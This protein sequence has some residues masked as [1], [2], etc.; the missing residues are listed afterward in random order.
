MS[1]ALDSQRSPAPAGRTHCDVSEIG[2]R[3]STPSAVEPFYAADSPEE[4]VEL[5]KTACEDAAVKPISSFVKLLRRTALPEVS[6]SDSYFG[7]RGLGPVLRCLRSAKVASLSLS[8]CMLSS[9]HI[10][11]VRRQLS[12]H[13]FLTHLDVTCNSLGPQSA[14]GLLELLRRSPQLTRVDVDA[15]TSKYEWIQQVCLA[16]RGIH[17]PLTTCA[18]C[19]RNILGN[20]FEE[21]EATL[22]RELSR[23]AQTAEAQNA[24][25]ECVAAVWAALRAALQKN[26]NALSVCGP[27]CL[28]EWV[29]QLVGLP[30]LVPTPLEEEEES[31][32]CHCGVSEDRFVGA[33]LAAPLS[34]M[35]GILAA[36][37]QKLPARVSPSM[38]ARLVDVLNDVSV[39]RRCA[40]CS[41]RCGRAVV[42]YGLCGGG[43]LL[44]LE[45]D[46]RDWMLHDHF[47][48]LAVPFA[49]FA[50]S[51]DPVILGQTELPLTAALA[52]GQ[53]CQ[54]RGSEGHDPMYTYAA[55]RHLS[56]KDPTRGWGCDLRSACKAVVRHGLLPAALAPFQPHDGVAR[57]GAWSSWEGMDELHKA[58]S[59]RKKGAFFAIDPPP[60]GMDLFDA[61]LSASYGLLPAR[62]PIVTG[63]KWR[64]E[65]TLQREGVVPQRPCK[66]GL[67]CAVRVL[68]QRIINEVAHLVVAPNLGRGVGDNGLFYFCREVANREMRYGSF[69][70]RDLA[71]SGIPLLSAGSTQT[72]LDKRG[73]V[74]AVLKLLALPSARSGDA[75]FAHMMPAVADVP[76]EGRFLFRSKRVV[77]TQHEEDQLTALRRLYKSGSRAQIH[78]FWECQ[79]PAAVRDW[80]VR[81]LHAREE[82]MRQAAAAPSRSR[83]VTV[84]LKRASTTSLGGA[85]SILD[86]EK[87]PLKKKVSLLHM[88]SGERQAHLDRERREEQQLAE[89]SN[90]WEADKRELQEEQ[91]ARA[92]KAE[93]LFTKALNATLRLQKLSHQFSARGA[94][95][96]VNAKLAVSQLKTGVRF[97][98]LQHVEG[99]DDARLSSSALCFYGDV[100]ATVHTTQPATPVKFQPT[101]SLERFPF[102]NGIDAVAYPAL[103]AEEVAYLFSKEAWV[104]YS[105]R[106]RRATSSPHLL[107]SHVT[108]R[109]LPQLFH[110]GIS[111]AVS[112]PGTRRSYLVQGR[113]VVLWDFDA[114][115]PVGAVFCLGDAATAFARLPAE[116][117]GGLQACAYTGDETCVLMWDGWSVGWSLANMAPT[118]KPV[119]ACSASS[120][121]HL[122][123]SHLSGDTANLMRRQSKHF[124]DESLDQQVPYG[125][126]PDASRAHQAYMTVAKDMASTRVHLD[127]CPCGVSYAG[128]RLMLPVDEAEGGILDVVA[129]LLSHDFSFVPHHPQA[130]ARVGV[131]Q[132]VPAAGAAAAAGGGDGAAD[133][134]RGVVAFAFPA[135]QSFGYVQ[136]AGVFAR[137][138]TVHVEA[139]VDSCAWRR[140]ATFHADSYVSPGQWAPHEASRCWRVVMENSTAG[141]ALHRVHW[142]KVS[143]VADTSRYGLLRTVSFPAKVSA[144]A[145]VIVNPDTLCPTSDIHSSTS[146][147]AWNAKNGASGWYRKHCVI[148]LLNVDG[149]PSDV[150][151]FLTGIDFVAWCY[152]G[153]C[154]LQPSASKLTRSDRFSNLPRPFRDVGIDAAVYACPQANPFLVYL[155]SDA[156]YV[157]WNIHDNVAESDVG[158]LGAAGGKFADLPAPFCYGLDTATHL[159]HADSADVAFFR[160]GRVLV[161]NLDTAQVVSGG[162]E[163]GAG[164]QRGG[165]VFGELPQAA[166]FSDVLCV[167]RLPPSAGEGFLVLSDGT[168]M[169]YAD[170]GVYLG[171]IALSTHRRYIKLA[172]VLAWHVME[173]NSWVMV[174]LQERPQ[175]FVGCRVHC[176]L[177]SSTEASFKVQYSDDSQQWDTAAPL[178][179]RGSAT[180][181]WVFTAVRRQSHR[182]WRLLL[183][184]YSSA[185]IAKIEWLNLPM[186]QVYTLPTEV[187]TTVDPCCEDKELDSLFGADP[188]PEYAHFDASYGEYNEGDS[189][190]YDFGVALVG[191]VRLQCDYYTET[192]SPRSLKSSP[193]SR[194]KRMF[195]VAADG[196]EGSQAPPPQTRSNALS[197]NNS[198]E[199]AMYAA[200]EKGQWQYLGT[201]ACLSDGFGEAAWDPFDVWRFWKLKL[202]KGQCRLLRIQASSYSGPLPLVGTG[203]SPKSIFPQ[204]LLLLDAETTTCITPCELPPGRNTVLHYDYKDDPQVFVKV[205]IHGTFGKALKGAWSVENSIDGHKWTPLSTC[206]PSGAVAE[207]TWPVCP[208]ARHWRVKPSCDARISAIQWLVP[209]ASVGSATP[210]PHSDAYEVT[211]TG[212]ETVAP[213]KKLSQPAAATGPPAAAGR[214]PTV[215]LASKQTV[216]FATPDGSA[217]ALRGLVLRTA[218]AAAAGAEVRV[219]AW[220]GDAA[221]DDAGSDEEAGVWRCVC[222]Q[223]VRAAVERLDWSHVGGASRWRVQLVEGESL[224]VVG[225]TWLSGGFMAYVRVVPES[226]ECSDA[227]Q[228]AACRRVVVRRCSGGGGEPIRL[229]KHA[230][231]T[232]C[233]DRPQ[234]LLRCC[235]EGA[236][237]FRVLV[238]S[239][240]GTGE[241][242]VVARGSKVL[243]WTPVEQQTVWRV[244]AWSGGCTVN[245]VTMLA[246]TPSRSVPSLEPQQR[247]SARVEAHLKDGRRA[248]EAEVAAE[249]VKRCN[250]EARDV[251][252]RVGKLL[253]AKKGQ[254]RVSGVEIPALAEASKLAALSDLDGV[255]GGGLHMKE[256]RLH[257]PFDAEDHSLPRLE[258]R[259][260]LKADWVGLSGSVVLS[261]IWRRAESLA[262]T[263]PPPPTPPAEHI[264]LPLVAFGMQTDWKPIATFPRCPA[265]LYLLPPSKTEALLVA[266]PQ[267]LQ[268]SEAT[269]LTGVGPAGIG[270][271][272]GTKQCTFR[273]KPG[274]S[275][276]SSIEKPAADNIAS[277]LL[278]L[279]S[280]LMP[281][282]PV[283]GVYHTHGLNDAAMTL[284]MIT[285]PL[286][287]DSLGATAGNV[288]VQLAGDA[289]DVT[290]MRVS[291]IVEW[292]GITFD[293]DGVVEQRDDGN[294]R[295]SGPALSGAWE[296][297]H[298]VPDGAFTDLVVDIRFSAPVD[299]PQ[300]LSVSAARVFGMLVFPSGMSM[301]FRIDVSNDCTMTAFTPFLSLAD[302]LTFSLLKPVNAA[303][304]EC[305]WLR[306]TVCLEDVTLLKGRVGSELGQHSVSG[307]LSVA[308]ATGICSVHAFGGGRAGAQVNA[309]VPSISLGL[310]TLQRVAGSR[311]VAV[312][313]TLS[314]EGDVATFKGSATL[315]GIH[316]VPATVR[317]DHAA[318]SFAIEGDI[319]GSAALNAHLRGTGVGAAPFLDDFTMS[320]TLDSTKVQAALCD[321]VLRLP[322]VQGIVGSGLQFTLRLD[323]LELQ[324]FLLSNPTLVVRFVGVIV[325]S[326]FDVCA[327]L[328]PECADDFLPHVA[329]EI[330]EQCWAPVLKFYQEHGERTKPH[331]LKIANQPAVS[332][333]DDA[334]NVAAVTQDDW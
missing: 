52:V 301:R 232:M 224:A 311:G 210:S 283:T 250:A 40:L 57:W 61:L 94:Q 252:K 126:P 308:G 259:A 146:L 136:V 58:A 63:V 128:L 277:P 260:E 95:P 110:A 269:K 153:E 109:D 85:E 158:I 323:G 321:L 294:L 160:Q 21:L 316:N 147:V 144:C 281:E 233:F 62:R 310:L 139:S 180:V 243:S 240:D 4:L 238:P 81:L 43:G 246:L 69:A 122:L 220:V 256:F 325:G 286:T 193:R 213:L 149:M 96:I 28:H 104:T 18:Y 290:S 71:A 135:A 45:G 124:L 166:A 171:P 108:F 178:T 285:G 143:T 273:L 292:K 121:L 19:R 265:L 331:D 225:C 241:W 165:D 247:S 230:H 159:H 116:L 32:C 218:G 194:S 242:E 183:W 228:Q 107:S 75:F 304:A 284:T 181:T 164:T 8:A 184:P 70:F 272:F 312:A 51:D 157:L 78:F 237:E 10:A 79:N 249:E 138:A 2:S 20:T 319:G 270:V 306:S 313:I 56:H 330:V 90:K 173:N 185:R 326:D 289:Q 98:F 77:A 134:A 305:R 315:V 65:W 293:V 131:L 6:L 15:G 118:G 84:R 37:L 267:A 119:H 161:W 88:S 117:R 92:V 212:E 199:W 278:H 234:V 299:S 174:D 263:A 268:I 327:T 226:V 223:P 175:M 53:T 197:C 254:S 114:K 196:A 324:P 255:L 187:T 329:S 132:I 214:Q 333:F 235:I 47:G 101:A 320:G 87:A 307:R 22:L 44:P 209:H 176:A 34:F 5:Y 103:H 274:V 41:R 276:V 148:P 93:L 208:P 303:H 195:P 262:S 229:A 169:H 64:G 216:T 236:G 219:E 170:G 253:K 279:L 266:T 200:R 291:T 72:I 245:S 102:Y 258:Y 162:V 24:S 141:D 191:S 23:S 145:P 7:D 123:P 74:E 83:P 67:L 177:D 113:S 80:L 100:V 217:D 73:D 298:D 179:V 86:V 198:C 189:L 231:F 264:P 328:N 13:P 38:F 36:E 318:T 261:L 68:G 244:E 207:L 30:P 17:V 222:T 39:K 190:S 206:T 275:V 106:D 154:P 125:K 89:A 155:F 188:V 76:C 27:E 54:N 150:A 26:G 82:S 3:V 31:A 227:A 211:T 202:V 130:K 50:C 29:S 309:S 288:C 14:K 271:S 186:R 248:P 111:C 9:E 322:L 302:V 280:L 239:G 317:L 192:M 46:S 1:L 12:G 142:Y 204:A 152:P 167:A 48:V 115:Q 205:V 25:N 129:S 251:T 182:F 297:M 55:A 296:D 287:L 332:F 133:G 137:G 140:V 91:Q 300:V 66:G 221:A 59:S 60:R 33:F 282:D 201:V 127:K 35:Q 49:D 11:E 215:T 257:K 168:W 151:L 16:N 156:S 314:D 334:T 105:L 97:A 172:G 203:N 295:L 112:V 42:R 99:G 163:V 120:I